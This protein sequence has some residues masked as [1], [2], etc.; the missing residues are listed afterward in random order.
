MVGIYPKLEDQMTTWDPE[1]PDDFSP[2]R[3]DA[4]VYAATD[5]MVGATIMRRKQMRD[6]RLRGRR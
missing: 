4:L 2:D 6:R 1:N 5:T 3:M